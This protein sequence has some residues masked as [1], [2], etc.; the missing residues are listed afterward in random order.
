MLP[1]F[2]GLQSD[3]ETLEVIEGG[4]W[5]DLMAAHRDKVAARLSPSGLPNRYGAIPFAFPAAIDLGG[6]GPLSD[7]L[8]CRQRH[9]RHDVVA[10]KRLLLTGAE[11]DVDAYL[12]QW[13]KTAVNRV[14]EAFERVKAAEVEG[15]REKSYFYR[16]SHGLP[17][18]ESDV[19]PHPDPDPGGNGEMRAHGFE[20]PEAEGMDVDVDDTRGAQAGGVLGAIG[21]VNTARPSKRRRRWRLFHVKTRLAK[22]YSSWRFSDKRRADGRRALLV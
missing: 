10:E 1:W 15:F 14:C 17:P 2:C 11:A 8:V 13:R 5:D 6:L 21:S 16:K 20:E 22:Q 19:D 12:E 4:T 18:A 9:D 7:A 3:L